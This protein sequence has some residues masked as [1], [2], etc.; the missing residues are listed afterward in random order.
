M[1]HLRTKSVFTATLLWLSLC[2]GAQSGLTLKE[3]TNGTFAYES[4]KAA[5]PL[6]D[7]KNYGQIDNDRTKVIMHAFSSG[8]PTGV[9]FDV[10]QTKQ[11]TIESFDNYSFSP[12]GKCLLIQTN[13][14]SVYRRSFTADYYIYEIASR[15]LRPLSVNGAQQTPIWSPD[16]RRIAFVRDNNI[17]LVDTGQP[18]QEVQV[19]HDGKRNAVINGIP[20]WVYEEE[21]GYNSA[22]TFNADGT[23]LCWVRFDE[24]EVKTYALQLFQGM[25][26]TREEYADY[27]GEYQYKYPKAGQENSKVTAWAYDIRSKQTIHLNIPGEG[28]EGYMP[29][30]KATRDASQIVFL[31]LNRHQDCLRIYSADPANGNAK[32]LFEE[33]ADKFIKEEVV[34]NLQF[35]DKHFILPSDRDGSMQL[36]LYDLQGNLVRK[37]TSGKHIV[38]DF[39][40]YDEKSQQAYFQAT[41]AD[42]MN[43]QVYV[44]GKDGKE[45]SLTLDKGCNAALFSTDFK[46]FLNTWSDADTPPVYTLR[47]H[48]GKVLKTLVDNKSLRDKLASHNIPHKEFFT[49]TTSEGITLN[50]VMMKPADFDANKKYPVVMYQYSGPG[51]QQ[52]VNWW[53]IGSMGQGALFDHYFNQNGFIVVCVDGRGTGARGKDFEKCTYLRLGDLE[54]KDQVETALYLGKLPYVDAARIGIWG[55]SFGGFCTL[56]SMSEG[57]DVFRAGVAVAPPTNWKYYDSVYTERYMRTPAENADGYTVNPIE[58]AARLHGAL[59]LCHGLADDN[60]HPQNVFEYSEKL[61]QEDK[62]FKEVLYTNRN[63][64]IFGGNTRNH[65][66]RQIVDFF[67]REMR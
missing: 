8:K 36:Y 35:T 25:S 20:D 26:P 23:H 49:F 34:E 28:N 14:R 30:I 2:V 45:R 50:G 38:L 44:A 27:P 4:V 10:T 19:T 7:G 18:G 53:N 32:L 22:M 16:S 56:M 59:L 51:S 48:D 55:W 29:R 52:V 17:F 15:K 33:K 63:H 31:T 65:I 39:Y 11:T 66:F 67:Q 12:D 61:V 47:D 57:R 62:D 64:S 3:I 6:P 5:T 24:S 21:F 41:A 40:G 60:V 43:R 13:T 54:S 1:L 46:Y 37:L 42:A 9:L 58:R